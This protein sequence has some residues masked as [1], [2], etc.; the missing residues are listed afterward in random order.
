ML[1]HETTGKINIFNCITS[2]MIRV[3]LLSKLAKSLEFYT[4]LPYIGYTHYLVPAQW[5]ME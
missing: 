1:H 2:E 3:L 5:K 4:K